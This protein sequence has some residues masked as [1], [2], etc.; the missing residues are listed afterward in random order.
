M[1]LYLA[2]L[3]G[4]YFLHQWCQERQ[5]VDLARQLD[6]LGLRVLAACLTQ[7]GTERPEKVTLQGL[8]ATILDVTSKKT[9]GPYGSMLGLGPCSNGLGSW[10]SEGMSPPI[11]T[12]PDLKTIH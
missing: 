1:W 7:E 4:L 11:Y 2:A 5:T 9:T 8:K 3:R 10:I 6:L 12:Y